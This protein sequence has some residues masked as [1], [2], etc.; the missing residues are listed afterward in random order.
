MTTLRT[1][2]PGHNQGPPMD[3]MQSWRRHCWK[4][5]K[6]QLFRPL[7]LE[8]VRRRV[9][10]AAR[11]GLTYRRYELL[12][13]GGGEIEAMLFADDTLVIRAPYASP[14]ERLDPAAVAKLAALTGCQRLMLAGPEGTQPVWARMPELAGLLDARLHMPAR[15]PLAAPP[16]RASRDALLAGLRARALGAGSVALVGNGEH[17]NAWVAGARLAGFVPGSEYFGARSPG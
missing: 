1:P 7:P 2:G 5:A 9:A 12:V 15:R 14:S 16:D 17:G 11:L 8:T 4:A 6:K 3:P 13:L 10:R